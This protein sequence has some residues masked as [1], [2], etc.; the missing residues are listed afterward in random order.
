M[1]HIYADFAKKYNGYTC[2][3]DDIS[4]Q[5]ESLQGVDTLCM[6]RG[7]DTERAFTG[8]YIPFSWSKFCKG[9]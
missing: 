1:V 4:L 9:F 2:G 8:R 5:I 3:L 6:H 7:H